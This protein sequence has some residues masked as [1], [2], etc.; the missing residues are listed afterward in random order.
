MLVKSVLYTNAP[1]LSSQRTTRRSTCLPRCCVVTDVIFV[2]T[3]HRI[4]S[5]FQHLLAMP[6]GN[7]NAAT[8]LSAMF[9]LL[10]MVGMTKMADD[11]VQLG[12]ER[13]A[14]EFEMMARRDDFFF[15]FIE[16]RFAKMIILA[17][18]CLIIITCLFAL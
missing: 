15:K 1:V 11:G 2:R 5:T 13:F 8:N 4:R 18:F 12:M 17:C 7:T 16:R 14:G 10:P 6:R 3:C 9:L